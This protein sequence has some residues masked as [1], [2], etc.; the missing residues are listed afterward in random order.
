MR[1]SAMNIDARHTA[2]GP[3][4][5]RG[6]V[7]RLRRLMGFFLTPRFA[8]FLVFGGLAALVNLSVGGTLYTVPA[9][10]AALPYWLAVAIGA[11]CGLLVN[12]GLNYALNFRYF[13]RS[14][15]SQ[16]RTFTIVALGGVVLTAA[17]AQIL[18]TLASAVGFGESFPLLGREIDVEFAAHVA[19]TG[20]VTLYSFAAHSLFSFNVGIRRGVARALGKPGQS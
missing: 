15:G 13:G 5:G 1:P 9:F 7:A 11:A 8:R 6:L 18:V 14:V 4:A 2:T 10:A 17:L 19:A 20:L 16:L 3:A 12:F